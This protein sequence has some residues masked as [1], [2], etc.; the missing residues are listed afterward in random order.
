MK[1]FIDDARIRGQKALLPPAILVEE[2]PQDELTE[3]VVAAGRDA[4]EQIV[5]QESDKL[6]AII[7]PCS[8][9]DSEAAIEYAGRLKALADGFSGEIVV[10][11]R[12]Y[13]EKPRTIMGWKGLIND[14]DLDETYRINK[15]LRTA[16]RLL[17]EISHLGLPAGTEFLDTNLPQHIAD[18]VSWGAIG[19]RTTE[20]QVHRALASGMSMPMGFKNATDGDAQVAIE[21]VQSASRA[22]WFPSITKEGV[23]AI[24]QSLGN[25]CCHV[26]LR[27]GTKT[28]PNYGAE[29][30]GAVAQ[31]L[32]KLGLPPAVMV[33]CS[34]GNSLKDHRR[35]AI[36]VG[37]VAAQVASGSVDISGVMIES[38]LVEGRQDF[39]PETAKYGQSIT[40]ACISI[41]QT[42]PI[43]ESLA[44]AVRRR[45]G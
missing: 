40:D 27:G 16:R 24:F 44:N 9:H 10:V 18:F 43:L 29:H 25:D 21:A 12:A 23:A 5:K 19:A 38:H 3:S 17:F 26:I 7:G 4:V 45:R 39:V 35:Q 42:E 13:F 14:P 20:S 8:I 11:M 34:H 36:V 2:F 28:G 33:D 6:L 32:C 15:G 1:P 30:V 37:D 41:E 22:H 31:K